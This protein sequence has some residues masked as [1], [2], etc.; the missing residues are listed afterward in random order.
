LKKNKLN[1]ST[2][3][4]IKAKSKR[5]SFKLF[6][7]K[8]EQTDV[9]TNFKDRR[10]NKQNF[11]KAFQDQRETKGVKSKPFKQTFLKYFKF[12]LFALANMLRCYKGRKGF[13]GCTGPKK[14]KLSKMSRPPLYLKCLVFQQTHAS[15]VLFSLAIIVILL[16]FDC[17]DPANLRGH[18]KGQ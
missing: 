8:E 5:T 15:Q 3:F 2:F 17:L 18:L 13:D 16:Y 1:C 14:L 12:T 9:V 7:I 4:R 11:S 10:R 6:R